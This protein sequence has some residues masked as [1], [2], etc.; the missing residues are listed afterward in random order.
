METQQELTAPAAKKPDSNQIYADLTFKEYQSIP[1]LNNS[2]LRLLTKSP[3]H[4]RYKLDNPAA[5]DT[6]ALVI[7]RAFHCAVLEPDAFRLDYV[8]CAK[9]DKRTTAGKEEA[10]ALAAAHDGKVILSPED[11]AQVEAMRDALWDHDYAR[12]LLE[13]VGM[14]EVSA[15]WTDPATGVLCKMRSDAIIPGFHTVFDLKTTE[16]ASARAFQNSI[17]RYGYHR[18]AAFYLDGWRML[19]HDFAHFVVIAIEKSPPYQ[20]AIY[21]LTP[22]S[23]ELGQRQNRSL[24]NL[25]KNCILKNDWPGYPATI[26][27]IGLPEWIYKQEQ[28][29]TEN[30]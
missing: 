18:Q 19:G 28:D 15:T 11:F 12:A 5:A 3:A 8:Q 16:D 24:I 22:R 6:P 21:R 23:V 14:V 17:A 9:I 1:A 27:D 30:E 10:A 26:Q 20:I 29:S 13:R 25:W 2:T 7:G 4:A